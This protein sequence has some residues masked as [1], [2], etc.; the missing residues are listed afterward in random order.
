M[1][2]R[3]WP[4]WLK[5]GLIFSGIYV[6]FL[7]IEGICRFLLVFIFPFLFFFGIIIYF[8]SSPLLWLLDCDATLSGFCS[9]IR[10]LVSSHEFF[11]VVLSSLAV[12]FVVGALIGLIVGWIKGKN[13]KP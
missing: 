3:Q 7:L 12:Y 4:R 13:A 8:Y 2:F 1:I 6:A 10:R 5:Y 11:F 9:T